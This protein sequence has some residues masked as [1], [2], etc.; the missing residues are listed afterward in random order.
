MSAAKVVARAGFRSPQDAGDAII[1]Y[2]MANIQNSR[3][4]IVQSPFPM[5]Q[6]DYLWKDCDVATHRAKDL[7]EARWPSA[8]RQ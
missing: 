4:I 1:D 5:P 2:P 6:A 8:L 3:R 7:R